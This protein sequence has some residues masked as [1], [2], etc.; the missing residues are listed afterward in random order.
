MSGI[1]PSD[2]FEFIAYSGAGIYREFVGE[3]DEVVV[4]FPKDVS[5]RIVFT[6]FFGK[7][8]ALNERGPRRLT[9]RSAL[10]MAPVLVVISRYCARNG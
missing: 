2:I 10:V 5:L 8:L 4:E 7:G 9:S 3:D 6:R 1:K